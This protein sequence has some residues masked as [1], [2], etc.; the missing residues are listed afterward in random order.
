MKRAAFAVGIIG[1]VFGSGCEGDDPPVITPLPPPE[2]LESPRAISGGSLVVS[3]DG[4]IAV[5]ADADLDTLHVFDLSD[6][7]LVAT[8]E[9]EEGDEPGR[10]LE[11]EDGVMYVALRSS[12]D[13][14]R[15]DTASGELQ[16]AYACPAPRGMAFDAATGS[17][18]VACVGGELV[19]LS[20]ALEV[21]RELRLERDLRDVL[22]AGEHLV[23]SRFRAAEA[24]I[25]DHEGGILHRVTPHEFHSFN[26]RTFQP[27]V[28]WRMRVLGNGMV[29]MIHQRGL[30][31]NV[32]VDGS[33]MGDQGPSGYGGPCDGAI[34]HAAATVFD[35]ANGA[36]VNLEETGGLG[37]LVLPV[38]G[39][40]SP[41]GQHL[42]IVAA[43]ND[44]LFF[45]NIGDIT[46][47]DAIN[48][49]FPGPNQLELRVLGEPIAVA[50]AP[51]GDVLVQTHQPAGLS[52][53]DPA[54]TTGFDELGRSVAIEPITTTAIPGPSRRHF[55]HDIFHKAAS[56][57]SPIACAS[58]H[59][60]AREDGRVWNFDTLGPRRTQNVS[61]GLLATL[62]LHWDGD[63]S[64]LHDLMGEVFVDRMGGST[65]DEERLDSLG[66]WLDA[67][68]IVAASDPSDPEAVARG[69]VLFHDAEV[70][71]AT[72]HSGSHFTN[73]A[74]VQVGTGVPLQV[75]S[76]LGISHRAPFMHNG[77]A[78]TLRDRFVGSAECSGS[79]NHGHVSGLSYAEIDDLV[80][81]L[82]T[83]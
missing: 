81:Y 13:V 72:C 33:G 25:L 12:G 53:V 39:D 11:G 10:I 76:L 17:L 48:N 38:D 7:S 23:V 50:F 40:V 49:C 2:Q 78:P 31:D 8:H 46:D 18:H 30:V 83:L 69:E 20:T 77:C 3:R 35:P 32:P 63:L 42:A 37:T 59:P 16:R 75:P 27:A 15:F 29:A 62:P 43:G 1:A 22:V 80:A 67:Q 36:I 47:G 45:S 14:V 66:A 65:P 71:C 58:C 57:F 24:L 82:D 51:N 44:R 5:A 79:D 41:D 74:T 6:L 64:D 26:G 21:T 52:R 4:A 54:Q 9:L 70:G 60:E 73:N 28:A 34:V 56:E 61:G 68:P 19:T 55:G